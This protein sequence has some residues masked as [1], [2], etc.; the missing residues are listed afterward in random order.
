MSDESV[1]PSGESVI[2]RSTNHKPPSAPALAGH[3][4]Q[5]ARGSVA[6]ACWS[7]AR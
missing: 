7:S 6:T 4:G 5:F 1:V 3:L 2:Q